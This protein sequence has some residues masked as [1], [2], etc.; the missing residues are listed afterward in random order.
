MSANKPVPQE[1]PQK[2]DLDKKEEVGFEKGG[3]NPIKSGEVKPDIPK[4]TPK[5]GE[6]IVER[7]NP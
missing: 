1:I 4:D 7:K 6:P 2:P 5:Q 3:Q